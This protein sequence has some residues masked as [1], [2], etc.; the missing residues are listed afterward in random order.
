MGCGSARRDSPAPLSHHVATWTT[1]RVLT[2]DLLPTAGV[3]ATSGK[4]ETRG[5]RTKPAA[6]VRE[7]RNALIAGVRERDHLS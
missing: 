7:L 2:P 1:Y 3:C 4:V 6:R 5:R